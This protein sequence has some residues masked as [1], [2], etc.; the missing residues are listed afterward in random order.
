MKKGR[1]QTV[2]TLY[3]LEQVDST[4]IIILYLL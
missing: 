3:I 1:T 2:Y 4:R